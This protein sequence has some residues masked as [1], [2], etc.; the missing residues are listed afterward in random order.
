MGI[1]GDP[2][3][4]AITK[5]YSY[6]QEQLYENRKK[7]IAAE[8]AQLDAETSAIIKIY[9]ISVFHFN[10]NTHYFEMFLLAGKHKTD[11]IAETYRKLSVNLLPDPQVS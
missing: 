2:G 5:T 6:I 1:E 11:A 7:H 4:V 10:V 3:W 8:N 9:S